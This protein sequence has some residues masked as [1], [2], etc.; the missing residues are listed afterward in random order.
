MV[1][2]FID[3][4]TA[5]GNNSF[6]QNRTGKL[7]STT[8]ASVG[9]VLKQGGKAILAVCTSVAI[10]VR[11]VGLFRLILAPAV[12]LMSRTNSLSK[13]LLYW[14]LNNNTLIHTP[15]KVLSCASSTVSTLIR[16]FVKV[17]SVISV[18]ATIFIRAFF[19]NLISTTANITRFIRALTSS[20]MSTL[21][22]DITSSVI[23]KSIRKNFVTS[24]LGQAVLNL[25]GKKGLI[26]V[27]I[28]S[29]STL[30]KSCLKPLSTVVSVVYPYL[31]KGFSLLRTLYVPVYN[32]CTIYTGHM[33]TFIITIVCT[34]S[35][36]LGINKVLNI[37]ANTTST[38][39]RSF[40]ALLSAV[41]ITLV[42][43]TR[44]ISI[45]LLSYIYGS[46]VNITNNTVLSV[47][48]SSFTKLV[49][50]PFQTIISS[51]LSTFQKYISK[52][53]SCSCT[54][55]FVVIKFI[56]KLITNQ[57]IVYAFPF[58]DLN[59]YAV[60]NYHYT[61]TTINTPGVSLTKKLLVTLSST[62][63]NAL[64]LLR[65]WGNV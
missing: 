52:A 56:S 48:T 12:S 10:F 9:Q 5:S 35:R 54:A 30:V 6:V 38:L 65:G 64:R 51:T 13:V 24:A 40:I 23:V 7:F 57:E 33:I 14:V 32:V 42:N 20:L 22:T 62:V 58:R 47:T 34:V 21:I 11:L 50:K 45:T 26:V 31:N 63:T 39:R 41:S 44:G 2:N 27:V 28:G 61:L 17:L 36:I 18:S 37:L 29:T 3:V 59:N 25:F 1:A 49:F 4:I 19:K 46:I 53:I 60:A 8:S 43:Y 55:S 16:G 15:I